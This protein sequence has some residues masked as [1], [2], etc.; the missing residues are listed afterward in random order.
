MSKDLWF[1][2][3]GR[4]AEEIDGGTLDRDG[5]IKALQR[6]GFDQR[7]AAVQYDEYVS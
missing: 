7:D 3:Q 2:E 6:L 4:I 5:A 1:I